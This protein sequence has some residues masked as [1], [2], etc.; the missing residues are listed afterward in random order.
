[1]SSFNLLGSSPV[2]MSLSFHLLRIPSDLMNS[3]CISAASCPLLLFSCCVC[4]ELPIFCL[5]AALSSGPARFSCAELAVPAWELLSD[6]QRTVKSTFTK[7]VSLLCLTLLYN[8]D[9]LR[10]ECVIS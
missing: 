5:I 4:E 6:L 9:Q 3:S 7:T 8:P 10:V 2:K 1:M